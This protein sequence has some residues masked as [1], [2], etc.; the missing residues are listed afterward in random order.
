MAI[1]F[2]AALS[3]VIYALRCRAMSKLKNLWSVS[4]LLVVLI[5]SFSAVAAQDKPPDKT[6]IVDSFK[7]KIQEVL[8]DEN[9]S[10]GLEHAT[11]VST[12]ASVLP[13]KKKMVHQDGTPCSAFHT[14]MCHYIWLDDSG[15]EYINS[16]GKPCG[17]NTCVAWTKVFIATVST[18]S[19][20]VKLT[21]S[22]VT[23]YT[24]ILTYS[25]VLWST[26][27][28]A[29]KKEAEKDSNFT[30]SHNDSHTFSYGYQNEKWNLLK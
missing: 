10:T 30:S 6:V 18:Y 22:L 7:Q 28:H 26:A 20:D 4:D 14:G 25:E 2:V 9:L 12:E 3:Y 11:V 1:P 15:A 13:G 8:S 29:T 17:G 16:A 23:P 19:F 5:V 24:G 27:M 21:D